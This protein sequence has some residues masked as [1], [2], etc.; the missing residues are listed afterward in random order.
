VEPL[1]A[2]VPTIAGNIGG[3]PEVV[4]DGVTGALVPIRNPPA[5][6]AAMLRVIDTP[7]RYRT[8]ARRGGRLVA[9]MF[10][11]R[12]TAREVY[13]AYCHILNPTQPPPAEFDAGSFLQETVECLHQ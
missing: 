3:L 4:V 7:E 12:R 10:D 2:E 11:V 13:Q 6:A 9:E 8:M 5:L 1:L